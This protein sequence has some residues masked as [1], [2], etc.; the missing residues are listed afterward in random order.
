MEEEEEEGEEKEQGRRRRKRRESRRER[1][2]EGVS[3][4]GL[5]SDQEE[6]S[7]E[8]MQCSWQTLGQRSSCISA[9]EL[10]TSII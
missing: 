5:E 4:W 1:R 9:R 8:H 10:S 6:A 2:K 3:S 7:P